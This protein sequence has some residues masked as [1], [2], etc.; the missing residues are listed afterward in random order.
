[1]QTNSRVFDDLAK[2]ASGALG[3]AQGVKT[4]WENLFNQRI[5]KMISKADIVKV[6][7]EDL[8]WMLPGAMSLRQKA[9]IMQEMGPSVII[10]T[11]GSEGATG[12]LPHGT[13]VTVAAEKAQI[14]DTVGAGDT[15]N[16]GVLAKLFE[17]GLLTKTELK[18]LPPRALEQA[19]LHGARAA[20][21]AVSRA[22]ANPPW[23]NEF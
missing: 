1:M 9:E 12:F 4:E 18:T 14:V 5:E 22:G 23:A 21:I 13:E 8:N 16:A 11:R 10:L 6:S 2:L 20:A 19:L 15:F 17:L 3:T 7:D